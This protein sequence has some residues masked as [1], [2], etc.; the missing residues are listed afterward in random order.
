[1]SMCVSI[2][3]CICVHLCV[4]LCTCLWSVSVCVSVCIRVCVLLYLCIVSVCPCIRVCVGATSPPTP[5]LLGELCPEQGAYY[6]SQRRGREGRGRGEG[7]GGPALC[8]SRRESPLSGDPVPPVPCSVPSNHH[9][10]RAPGPLVPAGPTGTRESYSLE[11][12]HGL[13]GFCYSK[14]GR[15]VSLVFLGNRISGP[16]P[17]QAPTDSESRIVIHL[18]TKCEKHCPGLPLPCA[19]GRMV[20][21]LI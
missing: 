19:G 6:G 5:T 3:V 12:F 11:R 21:G 17:A 2:Y 16:S 8:L 20:W 18:N 9:A 1:M 7:K 4:Y 14:C 13:Q 10:D 15:R